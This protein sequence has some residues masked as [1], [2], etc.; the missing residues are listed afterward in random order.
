MK[1]IIFL[2]VTSFIIISCDNKG[3]EL[4]DQSSLYGSWIDVS[5]YPDS[6]FGDTPPT[7]RDAIYRVYSDGTYETENED[8]LG[9]FL[10][11][12]WIFN[13]SD[14][15]VIFIEKTNIPDSITVINYDQY[16]IFKKWDIIEIDESNLDV[17]YS[18]FR[19]SSISINPFTNETL[20]SIEGIDI[21]IGRQFERIE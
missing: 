9:V 20:D 11:G 10:D 3:F 1:K 21:K 18:I 8:L 17:M 15:S 7:F 16:K 19:E 2:F 5:T 12:Q 13:D 14:N 6:F 4:I